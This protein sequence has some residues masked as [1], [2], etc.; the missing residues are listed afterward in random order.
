MFPLPGALPFAHLN[1]HPSGH[2]LS[3][4]MTTPWRLHQPSVDMGLSELSFF[5]SL[6][7]LYITFGL[8]PQTWFNPSH[9]PCA[10]GTNTN[11]GEKNPIIGLAIF[12][13]S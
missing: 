8:H 12:T 2:E 5:L 1:S 13:P 4:I 7:M 9:S 11:K 3:A 10:P 6:I